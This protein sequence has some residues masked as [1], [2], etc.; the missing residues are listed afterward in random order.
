MAVTPRATLRIWLG[1]F[2]IV[3]VVA[4]WFFGAPLVPVLIA[5]GLTCLWTLGR[6]AVAQRKARLAA[7][8]S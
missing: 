5:G 1:S 3:A 2:L 4:L 6:Y 7:R 8:N